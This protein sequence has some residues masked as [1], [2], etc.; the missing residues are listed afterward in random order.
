MLK[1]FLG[2]LSSPSNCGGVK[3]YDG[4]AFSAKTSN[5]SDTP[6]NR[7]G[8]ANP[9]KTVPQPTGCNGDRAVTFVLLRPAGLF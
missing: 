2:W 3:W 8:C 6:A 9:G 1:A 5:A 4:Q 7:R